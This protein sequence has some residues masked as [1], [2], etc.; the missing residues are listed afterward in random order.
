MNGMRSIIFL[1]F[2]ATNFMYLVTSEG[3]LDSFPI[4]L[5]IYLDWNFMNLFLVILF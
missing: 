3:N 1:F 2:S 4:S 5:N